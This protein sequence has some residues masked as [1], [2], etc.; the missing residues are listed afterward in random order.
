MASGI[1]VQSI[2]EKKYTKDE[3]RDCASSKEEI[4]GTPF[5]VYN[6][7]PSAFSFTS[8][9]DSDIYKVENESI[10]SMRVSRGEF[11]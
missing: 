5:D 11:F 2:M 10:S 8:D 4:G 3:Q 9:K 1:N 7:Q 6:V